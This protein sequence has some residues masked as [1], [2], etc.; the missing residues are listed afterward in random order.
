MQ[1]TPRIKICGITREQD[2]LYAA[3]LGVDAVGFVLARSPRRVTPGRI[4][5]ITALLPPFVSTVGVFVDTD[6]DDVRE[7]VRTCRLDWVQLHGDEP[8]EYCADLGLNV[9]KA[10]RV[11]DAA[12]IEAMAA[13][14]DHVK[15]FV[16][17]TYV[18]RQKGG[19]GQTFDWAL[20]RQAR[21]FGPVILA[22]GLTAQTVT[23]AINMAEP[24]G[25]DVSSGVESAPGI[26][27]HDRM[28]LFVEAVR[29]RL[30]KE[31]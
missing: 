4:Q 18:E 19:T 27:D 14:R 9:L 6:A 31:G 15:G 21:A 3:A 8:P 16:L 7:I 25:V 24:Y 11:R 13:Y 23:E 26:K 1:A 5:E 10:I 17:D 30:G 29:N 12:S 28:R 20:A 2:A 22:G